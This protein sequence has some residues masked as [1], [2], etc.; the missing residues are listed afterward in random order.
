MSPQLYMSM[1]ELNNLINNNVRHWRQRHQQQWQHQHYNLINIHHLIATS[2]NH[3]TTSAYTFHII[4]HQHIYIPSCNVSSIKLFITKQGH[5]EL[6]APPKAFKYALKVNSKQKC[7]D[8]TQE[9]EKDTTL[10][11]YSP[12]RANTAL[13]YTIT[14]CGE[15]VA[16]KH[17]SLS[18]IARRGEQTTRGGERNRFSVGKCDF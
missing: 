11:G 18:R 1:H 17:C 14:R 2:Y 4:V 6:I 7:M 15:G 16:R 12:W 5:L 9:H 3:H 8:T 13:C 10:L